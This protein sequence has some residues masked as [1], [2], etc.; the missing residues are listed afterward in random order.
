MSLMVL[1]VERIMFWMLRAR[2]HFV[3]MLAIDVI[4]LIESL[5]MRIF[6]WGVESEIDMAFSM[7]NVSAVYILK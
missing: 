3:C 5:R 1:L 6:S 2:L 7:A 4:A